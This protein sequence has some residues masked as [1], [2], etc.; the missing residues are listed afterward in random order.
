MLL[1][2]IYLFSFLI[3][4]WSY[5]G[6]I[7]V[8]FIISKFKNQEENEEISNEKITMII[9]TFNEEKNISNKLKNS[10]K[11]PY[12]KL[13]ILIADGGSTDK[14][15]KIVKSFIKRYKNVKLLSS[16]KRLGKLHDINKALK[17]SKG[18]IIIITDADSILTKNVL[19]I[20][21]KKMKETDIG[22]VG[23]CTIPNERVCLP[24]EYEY[25][26]LSNKLRFLESKIGSTSTVIAPCYAFKRNIIKQFPKNVVADDL[27]TTLK[28]VE[29][30]YKAVYMPNAIVYEMRTP[31]NIKTM[32]VQKFRKCIADIHEYKRFG[33]KP[34]GPS[35]FG[36]LI[37]PTKLLQF[38]VAPFLIIA[39]M[40]LSVYFMFYNIT[41][42][43]SFLLIFI[44]SIMTT[45]LIIKRIWHPLYHKKINIFGKIFTT[46]LINLIII[47]SILYYPFIEK[48]SKYKRI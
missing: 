43:L 1:E 48:S 45:N 24:Y 44:L 21:L 5:F 30:G 42:P 8:L 7:I 36:S 17:I 15:I 28:S 31:K 9:P 22:T 12:K 25:W 16:T 32:L 38:F 37:Y 4:W 33:Y 34:F 27:Y 10:V 23:I 40:A 41:Q 18:D 39:F 2:S 26:I 6:Y 35:I 46:F 20:I 13:E 14:T 11:I 3:F 47:C 19:E 29:L